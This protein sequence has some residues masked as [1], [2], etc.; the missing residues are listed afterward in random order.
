MLLLTADFTRIS[1]RKMIEFEFSSSSNFEYFQ[2]FF[3]AS[4]SKSSKFS[5]TYNS[6][7]RS[8]YE[9]LLVT[10]LLLAAYFPVLA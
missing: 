8:E 5:S 9:Y 4:T 1:T 3:Q 7:T 10:T 2:K 6:S